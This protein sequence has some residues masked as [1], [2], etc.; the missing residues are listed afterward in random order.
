MRVRECDRCGKK[1]TDG[2]A[3]E[4]CVIPT[5][6]HTGERQPLQDG[7][8]EKEVQG[9]IVEKWSCC[10]VIVKGSI[11]CITHPGG[12][13]HVLTSETDSKWK[14]EEIDGARLCEYDN[15]FVPMG[16]E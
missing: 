3:N 15:E 2:E 10:G 6:D 8:M 14:W 16:D 13:R 9:T 4:E 12:D 7:S 11:G 5:H 1:M